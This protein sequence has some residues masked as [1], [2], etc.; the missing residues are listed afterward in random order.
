[1]NVIVPIQINATQ[2]GAGC[3][4]S[5]D[6]T[7]AWT[8]GTYVIGD[9]R[10]VVSTHRVY[11]CAVAGASTISP[12]LEPTRWK[13]MRPTNKMAPFDIYTST[14]ATS[15]STDIGYPITARF[16]NALALY[17][18]VGAT[19]DITVKDV[20][21]GTVIYNKTGRL[22]EPSRGWYSYYFGGRRP[23]AKI[24]ATGIPIRPA[25]EITITIHAGSGA[26]RAL[27]MIVLGKYRSLVGIGPWGGTEYGSSVEPVSY[28]Y[29]STDNDGTTTWLP[30]SS[31]TNLHCKI[32]LPRDQ[33]DQSVSLLQE[34]LGI[35]V[36]CIGTAAAG[37]AGLTTFGIISAAPVSYNGYGH[38][39]ID[40]TVKGII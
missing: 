15:T 27:G 20:A 38:A 39:S 3:T 7:A 13:D 2:I 22:R 30:G 32:V 25:A 18:A 28:G 12:E 23:L 6:A 19:Y 5:E 29:N 9:E 37:Y 35:P 16:C 17:G 33:A 14:A 34:V 21:G 26:T 10:H 1:M 40:V 36:A 8:S 31:A 24:I 4:L 11:R